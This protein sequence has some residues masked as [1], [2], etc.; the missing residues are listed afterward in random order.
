MPR[1]DKPVKEASVR[2]REA[3]MIRAK[4]DDL[5]LAEEALRRGIIPALEDFV[6]RGWGSTTTH[7]FAEYKCSVLLQLSLQ[8]HITSFARVRRIT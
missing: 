8:P 1:R 7:A 4:L 5:G 2:R 6:D 3:E